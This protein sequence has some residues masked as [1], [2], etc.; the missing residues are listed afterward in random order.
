MEIQ[1]L[2]GFYWA[3]QCLSFS[4]AA[5]KIHVSQ[6]A[7]SHQ[8]KSLERE[9]GVKLYERRGRGIVPTD[10]GKRLAHHARAILNQVDDLETEFAE[11]GARPHGTVRIA[12][13]RGIGMYHLP[14][15][16]QRFRDQ[17]PGVRLVVS[18]KTF[19]PE[20]LRAVA[21]GEVDIGITTSWNE[22]PDV[23]YFE[24]LSFDMFV[25]TPLDHPW[26][27]QRQRLSLNEIADEPLILYEKGTSIRDNIDAV[28]ARHGLHPDVTME[29]GGF[30][31]LKE[32]VRIG[33]G[34]SISSGLMI[35][36]G[37]ADVINTT[38]VTNIFGRLG[39]GL[40]LRRGR[41]LS[42]AV[43]EF[44]QVAG[45]AEGRIPRVV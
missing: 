39:Y 30:L 4:E 25:C 34:V 31:A 41:F 38:P 44:M 10:E 12:A 6:S 29:V 42:S 1:K 45:V 15:V 3:I 33:L 37:K 18:S 36:K 40:V 22:F 35:S 13:C 16:V 27:G 43:Q 19:D 5:D 26:A 9:L 2:R 20:I 32:Y 11:L 7:V 14:R 28:F 24:I 17:H 23:E 8:V 21:S